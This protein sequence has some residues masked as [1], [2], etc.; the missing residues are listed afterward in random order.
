MAQ[1]DG[2]AVSGDGENEGRAWAMILRLVERQALETR[3]EDCF[4]FRCH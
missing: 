2:K 3:A 4:G 1:K